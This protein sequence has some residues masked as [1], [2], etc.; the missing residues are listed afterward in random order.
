MKCPMS[1]AC[2]DERGALSE[3][4]ERCAWLIENQAGNCA[5]AI[6]FLASKEAFGYAVK[7]IIER[8]A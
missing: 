6:A 4:D 2:S 7:N 3:C 5:C 8:G 1:F